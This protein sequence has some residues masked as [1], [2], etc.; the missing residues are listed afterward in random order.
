MP[1]SQDN[2]GI[3]INSPT[4]QSMQLLAAAEIS[5]AGNCVGIELLGGFPRKPISDNVQLTGVG[6]L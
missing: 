1:I 5:C 4:T 3:T 2:N 6:Y